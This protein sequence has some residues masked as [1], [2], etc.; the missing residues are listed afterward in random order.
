M[1]VQISGKL[2]S[3]NGEVDAISALKDV[4][5]VCYYFSAHWCPPCRQFTPILADL[6]KKWNAN[7]KKI[8]IVWLTLDRDENSWREYYQQMPW[9]AV[10]FGDGR[11]RSIAQK[12]GVRGIPALYIVSKEETVLRRGGVQDVYTKN[13]KAIEG[14]LNPVSDGDAEAAPSIDKFRLITILLPILLYLLSKFLPKL[15]QS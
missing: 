5:I 6:Y 14:W 10:P 1:A 12:M 13:E 2:I 4:P 3:K 11:S 15:W 7:E 8:E 9:L